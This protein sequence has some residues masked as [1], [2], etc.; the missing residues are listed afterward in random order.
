MD[1]GNIPSTSSI[2][3]RSQ[4]FLNTSAMSQRLASSLCDTR[5]VFPGAITPV[6]WTLARLETVV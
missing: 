1:V 4:G 5:V 2:K 3:L 6:P